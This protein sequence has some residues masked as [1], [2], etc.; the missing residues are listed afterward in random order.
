M[1]IKTK[2]ANW[3]LKNA[4]TNIARSYA[5][6]LR[7]ELLEMLVNEK[8]LIVD[9]YTQ[10]IKDK[11]FELEL[12]KSRF[13]SGVGIDVRNECQSVI[14]DDKYIKTLIRKINEY[15]IVMNYDF[16]EKK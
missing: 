6:R 11:I 12:S 4:E 7:T 8:K 2:L 14:Y 16:K 10:G 5:S 15:Q 1:G 13:R 9:D 3:V